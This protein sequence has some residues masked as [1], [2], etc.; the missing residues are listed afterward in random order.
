MDELDKSGKIPGLKMLS[1]KTGNCEFFADFE[2]EFDQ[3]SSGLS[4]GENENEEFMY[5]IDGVKI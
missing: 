4:D 2:R 5:G 1:K 3:S